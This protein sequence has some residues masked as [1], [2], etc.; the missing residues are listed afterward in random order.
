MYIKGIM[1]V[2]THQCNLRCRYCF[3]EKHPETMTIETAIDAV[4]YVLRNAE[5]G[6]TPSV[7]F[8]GGEP[9]LCWDS[10]IV[11]LVERY[12]GR[13]SFSMTTNGLLLNDERLKWMKDHDVGILFSIDGAKETQDYN[14]PYRNMEGSF[15][16]LEEN[17]DLISKYYQNVTFRS[18]AIPHT[19]EHIFENIMFAVDH[20]YQSFFV[21]P[22]VFEEW[23]DVKWNTLAMEM[24]KFSDYYIQCYRDGKKPINFSTLETAFSNIKRINRAISEKTY[25]PLSC[26]KRCGLGCTGFVSVHPNG[27]IYGCQEMTSVE[28]NDFYIGDIYNGI[29]DERLNALVSE[30]VPEEIEGDDCKHC[31][32][33]RICN[34]GCVANNFFVN[35]D[36]NKPP[37]YHCM[38]ERMILD[39][40]IYIANE[41]GTCDMF[42][43][44]W[45]R[46]VKV[47]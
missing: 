28:R 23:S 35:R 41:L 2:V 36:V 46:D 7:N 37:K 19:C 25:R 5:P 15:D 24:R 21:V 16:D 44:H 1:L 43:D 6:K 26:G 42:I 47:Y 20:G 8:F 9:T 45:R 3:V 12:E 22:N 4:E 17:I 38:W 27:D 14:R 10:I 33:N 40:A 13:L 30:F 11:P 18:T 34:G 29:D 32:M 39:E 31:K